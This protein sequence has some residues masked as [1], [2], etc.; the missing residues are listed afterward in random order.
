MH[1]VIKRGLQIDLN[2]LTSS[3]E[4]YP[5]VAVQ[6]S[7]DFVIAYRSDIS[8]FKGVWVKHFQDNG[9]AYASATKVSSDFSHTA[10]SIAKDS[11]GDFIIVYEGNGGWPQVSLDVNSMR[12]VTVWVVSL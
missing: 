8:I 7:G 12:V 1:W 6:E 10:P 3:T 2:T 4:A 11:A 5:V 9:S